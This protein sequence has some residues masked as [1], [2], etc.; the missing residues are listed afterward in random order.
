MEIYENKNENKKKEIFNYNDKKNNDIGN[1]NDNYNKYINED[2]NEDENN[3][4]EILKLFHNSHEIQH[5]YQ[6]FL[7]DA[8]EMD[9]FKDLDLF[10]KN[11]WD[12]L[13][14]KIK[15]YTNNH[16]ISCLLMSMEDLNKKNEKEKEKENEFI[17]N[18]YD[19]N[20]ILWVF[21]LHDIGKYINF[22]NQNQNFYDYKM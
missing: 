20:I 2:G 5:L 16:T 7:N 3:L 17:Y 15:N 1:D 13:K 12:E 4:K 22:S 11:E 19:K 14:S 21:L 9:I 8:I 6:K 10:F 18:D